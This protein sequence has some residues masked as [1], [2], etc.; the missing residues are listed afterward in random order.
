[1]WIYILFV[2]Q[3]CDFHDVFDV[4]D[5]CHQGVWYDEADVC[6]RSESCPVH[7]RHDT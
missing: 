7:A 1:M 4:S 5:G 3:L 2:S 6:D